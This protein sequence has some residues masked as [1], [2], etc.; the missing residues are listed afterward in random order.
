M[1]RKA[2][3]LDKVAGGGVHCKKWK[4]GFQKIEEDVL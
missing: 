2:E 4:P 1:R 3:L